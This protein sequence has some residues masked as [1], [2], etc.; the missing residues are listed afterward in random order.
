MQPF[1][2]LSPKR[3]AWR[4]A[5][6]A[7]GTFVVIVAMLAGMRAWSLSQGFA[8]QAIPGALPSATP[9]PPGGPGP[10]NILLLGVDAGP[11]DATAT[12]DPAA[13]LD[14]LSSVLLVHL[15]AERDGVEVSSIPASVPLRDDTTIGEALRSGGVTNA[16]EEAE[17]LLDTHIDHVA[18]IDDNAY[19]AVAEAFEGVTVTADSPFRTRDG[20]QVAAGTQRLDAAGVLAYLRPD[21]AQPGAEELA[22]RNQQELIESM[23][24]EA[25][26]GDTLTNL[27]LLADL[28][29]EV[30]PYIAVDETLTPEYLAGLGLKLDDIRSDVVFD[31]F[32][33]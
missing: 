19:A 22:M 24:G 12:P 21:P 17:G 11:A 13:H 16:V 5:S 33:G 14:G 26:S 27:R 28:S 10:Q 23:L 6:V 1:A 25:V 31:T 2:Q 20:G 8:F 3:M 30:N 29:A 7:V 4:V 18:V 32:R 9:G 15:P